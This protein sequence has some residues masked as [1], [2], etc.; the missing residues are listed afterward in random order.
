MKIFPVFLPGNC[1]VWLFF[2]TAIDQL[3]FF[4]LQFGGQVFYSSPAPSSSSSSSS[5]SFL[6][7]FGFELSTFVFA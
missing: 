6:A 1:I 3:E 7:V 5:S 4:K 2:F